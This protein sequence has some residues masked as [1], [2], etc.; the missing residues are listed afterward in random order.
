MPDKKDEILNEQVEMYPDNTRVNTQEYFQLIILTNEQLRK[1]K[2]KKLQEDNKQAHIYDADKARFYQNLQDRINTSLFGQSSPTYY[3]YST[4]EGQ[5]AIQ[6][7]SNQAASNAM[8]LIMNTVG[9]IASRP[10]LGILPRGARISGRIETLL[11]FKIGGGAEA[12]VFDNGL[13][14]LKVGSVSTKEMAKRNTIPNTVKSKYVGRV[15]T[16]YSKLSAYTQDKVKVL[17]D[18]TFSKHVDKLDKA[19]QKYGFRVVNDPNVQYRA[20]TNG[21]IVI[22]DIS[23]G[24]VG[25]DW[26]RR[27]KMI[28]FN[29]QTVPQWI[30]QGF[31]LKKGGKLYGRLDSRKRYKW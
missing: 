24:N 4:N 29:I 10:I 5:Q 6:A 30:E 9:G 14:V 12:E 8:D 21:S 31:T 3:D 18:E 23:P 26:L 1:I 15:K 16:P 11:P 13:Q 27:P 22:D 28:D 25:L 2:V 17:T 20:Y 7:A 19:M